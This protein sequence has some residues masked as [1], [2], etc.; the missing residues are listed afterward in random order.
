M[1]KG[2]FVPLKQKRKFYSH[3]WWLHNKKHIQVVVDLSRFGREYIN[4]SHRICQCYRK[5]G[6][7]AGAGAKCGNSGWRSRWFGSAILKTCPLQKKGHTLEFLREI[8]HLR[9]WTSA[10]SEPSSAFAIRW[11]SPF[12]NFSMIAA[13]SIFTPRLSQLRM[14]R[15]PDKCFRWPGPGK[16]D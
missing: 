15:V 10:C 5:S 6:G 2:G 9:P 8:A 1:S 13:S 16:P 14:P 12:T 4:P 7:V 3:K 11:H